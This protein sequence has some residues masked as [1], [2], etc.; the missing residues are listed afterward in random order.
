MKEMPTREGQHYPQAEE[1]ARKI[2]F[3]PFAYLLLPAPR[4]TG[5]AP[6]WHAISRD[7]MSSRATTCW[8]PR[9]GRRRTGRRRRA[10]KPQ[11]TMLDLETKKTAHRKSCWSRPCRSRPWQ[12]PRRAS[13]E[14]MGRCKSLISAGGRFCRRPR[15]AERSKGYVAEGVGFEPTDRVNGQRFSRPPLSATQPSLRRWIVAGELI[16]KSRCLPNSEDCFNLP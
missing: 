1:W 4:S 15:K 16:P 5:R 6:C 12:R 7:S 3:L 11:R 10:R 14:R 9:C 8:P 13:G 2:E